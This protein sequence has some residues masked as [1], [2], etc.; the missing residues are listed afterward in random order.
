MKKNLYLLFIISISFG[1]GTTAHY[2]VDT[3]IQS[4]ESTAND[5]ATNAKSYEGKNKS[6]LL[7][8]WGMPNST[9]SD[10][11]SGQIFHY[12]HSMKLNYGTLSI[13]INMFINS[14]GI[15]YHSDVKHLLSE[16]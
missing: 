1:C 9:Y 16:N 12:E 4:I 7:K 6:Y 15:V 3:E 14:S 13:Y 5:I 8:D 2:S 11:S 10:G